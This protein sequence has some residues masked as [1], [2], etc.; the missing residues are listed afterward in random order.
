V[1]GTNGKGSTAATLASILQAAGHRTGLYTSPHLLRINERIRIN[2][3]T[4]GDAEFAELYGDVDA[5]A[6]AL[7]D[8]GALPSH[9]NFFELLT[10]M[11]FSYFARCPVEIAVMEV[12]LGGRLDATNAAEPFLAVIADIALDHQEFLGN[13]I[14]EIA[15]EKAGIIH[16]GG[17][18][19]TLPQHP[20][21][22]EAIASRALECGAAAINAAPF[23]PAFSPA[24]DLPAVPRL[25][26]IPAAGGRDS[27]AY[28]LEVMGERILVDSPLVGR[29]QWRNIALAV[30][31]AEQLN[32]KGVK[33][34]PKNIEAGIRRTC[35]PGR[36]Q[37]VPADPGDG[38]PEVVLDVAHNPAG[39]WALR[40]ALSER[41]LRGE[42]SGGGSRPLT[43]VFGAMRD[44]AFGEIAEILFPLATHLVLTRA[45]SPRAA[46]PE[47]IRAALQRIPINAVTEE[48]VAGA[49]HRARGLAGPDGVLAI[50]G[51]LYIVGEALTLL[52]ARAARP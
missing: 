6:Q 48:N 28:P 19:V 14:G 38:W 24:A 12:G 11:A 32:R 33:I 44:K 1:A 15:R 10:A 41:Y 16:P 39:A 21:A 26:A 18:V 29:H 3:E 22:N 9:P 36:F 27:T 5:R 13:T 31:A 34:S 40:A 43:L 23:V 2:G 47:E 42:E 4:I 17:T 50:T 52:P 37:I 45:D 8:S 49:L 25:P 46:T 7:A 35:W 30:A 20:E 51:S